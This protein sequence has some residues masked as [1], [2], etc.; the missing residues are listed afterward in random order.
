MLDDHELRVVW[1]FLVRDAQVLEE[2]V[3]GFAEGHGGEELTSEPATTAC[4]V[5]VSTAEFL[6]GASEE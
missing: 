3:R 1:V 4:R 5:W 2:A 6:P